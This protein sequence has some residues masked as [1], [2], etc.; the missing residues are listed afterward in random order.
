MG[1]VPAAAARPI[2]GGAA[3]GDLQVG[4]APPADD[5]RGAPAEPGAR[6]VD[7]GR[8]SAERDQLVAS[9]A[10][11]RR[12]QMWKTS[13]PS[14]ASGLNPAMSFTG[15]KSEAFAREACTRLGVALSIVGLAGFATPYLP[16]LDTGFA[17]TSLLLTTG[18]L[19][20]V[21]GGTARD[22]AA[23]GLFPA[24]LQLL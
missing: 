4:R 2:A 16:G 22:A 10:L 3:C 9:R 19:G 7:G 8:E 13:I 6:A 18:A 14:W 1:G 5:A 24:P 12:G 21:V 11:P 23:S 15:L 17:H 20:I